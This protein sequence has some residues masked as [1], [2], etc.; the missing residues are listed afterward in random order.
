MVT[1]AFGRRRIVVVVG[2]GGNVDAGIG[3]DGA[4]ILRRHGLDGY[5]RGI[6]SFEHQAGD[7]G[8]RLRRPRASAATAAATDTDVGLHFVGRLCQP[9]VLYADQEYGQ[10]LFHL[11]SQLRPSDAHAERGQSG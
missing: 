6:V 2:D 5:G 11:H 8:L 7:A 1:A 3:F 10:L 9:V 4:P